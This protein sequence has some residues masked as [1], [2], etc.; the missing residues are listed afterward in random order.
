MQYRCMIDSQLPEEE[1]EDEE[2]LVF[3][4]CQG[5]L[6]E[7]PFSQSCSGLQLL[8]LPRSPMVLVLGYHGRR[9]LRS[10]LCRVIDGSHY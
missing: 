7:F 2:E 4:S 3:S 6:K 8:L 1:E 9:K 5:G 10:P